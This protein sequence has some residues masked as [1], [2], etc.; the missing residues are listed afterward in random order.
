MSYIFKGC[1]N[2]KNITLYNP[3]LNGKNVINMKD[4]FRGCSSLKSEGIIYKDYK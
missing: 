3:N 2:L 4:M 1:S